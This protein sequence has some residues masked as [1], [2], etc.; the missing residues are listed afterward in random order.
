M[1]T[2]SRRPPEHQYHWVRESEGVVIGR[3]LLDPVYAP[4]LRITWVKTTGRAS[5]TMAT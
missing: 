2:R 5:V 3:P 1:A 4:P